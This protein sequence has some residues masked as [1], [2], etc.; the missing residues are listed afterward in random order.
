MLPPVNLDEMVQFI[1]YKK[2]VDLECNAKK[3][4]INLI[5]DNVIILGEFLNIYKIVLIF[6]RSVFIITT[7]YRQT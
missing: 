4:E 2:K 6:L 7:V 5:T 1:E 3:E